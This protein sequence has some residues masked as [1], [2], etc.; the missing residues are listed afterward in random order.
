M[1][2]RLLTARRPFTSRKWPGCLTSS[3]RSKQKRNVARSQIFLINV[4]IN[5]A[6]ARACENK[7]K[8]NKATRVGKFQLPFSFCLVIRNKE[9]GRREGKKRRKKNAKCGRPRSRP[10]SVGTLKCGNEK[11]SWT[12]QSTSSSCSTSSTSSTSPTSCFSFLCVS[13][14]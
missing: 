14:F 5:F 13:S 12:C 9:K 1:L 10:K 2:N 7:T 6:R 8:K 11:V 3:A 4:R